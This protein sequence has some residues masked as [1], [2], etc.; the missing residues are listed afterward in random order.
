MFIKRPTFRAVLK[1]VVF[2]D[3]STGGGTRVA[4]SRLLRE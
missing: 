2:G 4:I 1:V 3:D